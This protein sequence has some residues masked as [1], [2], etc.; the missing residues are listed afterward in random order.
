MPKRARAALVAG[1]AT[2]AMV[3]APVSP[4]SAAIPICPENHWCTFDYYET[5]ERINHIGYAD[6]LCDGTVIIKG[7]TSRWVDLTSSRSCH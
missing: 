3:L 7:E 6:Q 2:A 1:V 4:A 5:H